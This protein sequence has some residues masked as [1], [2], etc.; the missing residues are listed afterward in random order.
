[1]KKDFHKMFYVAFW[2]LVLVETF[3]DI[4]SLCPGFNS[5]SGYRLLFG[6]FSGSSV[7]KESFQPWVG[8]IPGEGHGYPFQ[9]SWLENSMDR[10]AWWAT[11]HGVAKSP[12]WLTNPHFFIL[13]Y[14]WKEWIS[15]LFFLIYH[16][17]ILEG[18]YYDVSIGYSL[19]VGLFPFSYRCFLSTCLESILLW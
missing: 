11:V 15:S 4:S 18:N 5:W 13:P 14:F 3:L 8:K 1:M 16:K 10:G 7:G 19:M 6:G 9:Y 12:T 17:A 2:V